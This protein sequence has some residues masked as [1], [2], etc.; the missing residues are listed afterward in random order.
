MRATT[1]GRPPKDYPFN[2]AAE[3]IAVME[4]AGSRMRTRPLFQ[5]IA[6]WNW[7]PHRR[8]EMI[9]DPPPAKGDPFLLASLASVVHALCDRDGIPVPGWVKGVR[10]DEER[11]LSG[12][13]ADSK[14]GRVVR[15]KAPSACSEHGVYFEADEITDGAKGA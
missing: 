10:V 8:S 4:T 9:A 11:T 7:M 2:R 3:M 13:P 15:R 5:F 6:D 12:L 14:F 1:I